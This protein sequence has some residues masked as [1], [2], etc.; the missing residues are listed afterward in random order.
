MYKEKT[1]E[2]TKAYNDYWLQEENF[3][4]I[5]YEP[6]KPDS[7]EWYLY[8]SVKNKKLPYSTM[9]TATVIFFFIKGGLVVLLLMWLLVAAWCYENN[10]ELNENPWIVEKRRSK[11]HFRMIAPKDPDHPL[12]KTQYYLDN[13]KFIPKK[14]KELTEQEL[15]KKEEDESRYQYAVIMTDIDRFIK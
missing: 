2:E 3:P 8:H 1:L 11:K 5:E 7:E 13:P 4:D 12:Y 14:P 15:K 10:K 9:V 6:I